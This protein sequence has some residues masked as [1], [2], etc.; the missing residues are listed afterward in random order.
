MGMLL[1]GSV[2]FYIA[3]WIVG[4]PEPRARGVSMLGVAAYT[5]CRFIHGW[6]LGEI[7]WGAAWPVYRE[8]K[9]ISFAISLGILVIFAIGFAAYGIALLSSSIDRAQ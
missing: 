9:P 8:E 5:V 4:M 7:R 6:K 1:L 3:M 2:F